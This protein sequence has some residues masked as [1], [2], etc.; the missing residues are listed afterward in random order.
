MTFKEQ[1]RKLRYQRL[2]LR[3]SVGTAFG[4]IESQFNEEISYREGNLEELC[5][6]FIEKYREAE[7][8]LDKVLDETCRM[9]KNNPNYGKYPLDQL[10]MGNHDEYLRMRNEER[11]E[12][13]E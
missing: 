4:N 7:V 8:A 3:K 11:E 5:K 12:W 10:E 1:M 9:I 6:N 13:G 2:M